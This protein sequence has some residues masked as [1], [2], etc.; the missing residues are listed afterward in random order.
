MR[1]KFL[2]T[3]VLIFCMSAY[4]SSNECSRVCREGHTA[5]RSAK[6]ISA[7]AGKPLVSEQEPAQQEVIEATPFQVIKFLYI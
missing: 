5:N 7:G 6:E 1:L 2:Y 4:A 3:L